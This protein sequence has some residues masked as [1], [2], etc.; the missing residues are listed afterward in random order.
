[1]PAEICD[2]IEC[3]QHDL[4]DTLISLLY[5][6][7]AQELNLLPKQFVHKEKFD[8]K[9]KQ[10]LPAAAML[11]VWVVIQLST[12]VYDYYQLKKQ[13]IALRASLEK[14]YRQTFP[15]AK[16]IVNVEVQ[17]R[18][19][20][21]ELREQSGKAESGFTEMLVKSAPVLQKSPGLKLQSL[22]YHD[23]RMD[24]ELE[25]RDLQGLEQL[26][27]KLSRTGNWEV[28]IQSASSTENK[29]HGRLQVRSSS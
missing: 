25:I 15:D 28:E 2:D 21:K 4:S 11:L 7:S 3:E 18:Q 14:I 6:D 29:V 16:R 5:H 10:W 27:E 1:M 12:Q 17:M 26:K 8:K 22:R 23:G 9:F 19:R 13:D 24:I 20:L